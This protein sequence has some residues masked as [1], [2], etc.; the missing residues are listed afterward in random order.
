V[1]EIVVMRCQSFFRLAVASCLLFAGD[2]FLYAQSRIATRRKTD[3][4]VANHPTQ[5]K[6]RRFEE[7]PRL[8]TS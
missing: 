1:S 3:P 8:A 4:S 2:A 6:E 7:G 5:R